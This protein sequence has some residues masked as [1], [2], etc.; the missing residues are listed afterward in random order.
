MLVLLKG[1]LIGYFE[2]ADV[3]SKLVLAAEAHTRDV[4][5][6]AQA[7]N[8]NHLAARG[9]QEG[10]PL[11]GTEDHHKQ[12]Q[13]RDDAVVT[14]QN[15][16]H[17]AVDAPQQDYRGE[18]EAEKG[19][20]HRGDK[21]PAERRQQGIICGVPSGGAENMEHYIPDQVGF[22]RTALARNLATNVTVTALSGENLT[23]EDHDSLH[24]EISTQGA[25]C[26]FFASQVDAYV[27][28]VQG[29]LV[30][31]HDPRNKNYNS[32][33]SNMSSI[34]KKPQKNETPTTSWKGLAIP[35]DAGVDVAN[36][37]VNQPINQSV[38]QSS[39]L[40][41]APGI[42]ISTT[43]RTVAPKWEELS[44]ADRHRFGNALRFI[45]QSAPSYG[46]QPRPYVAHKEKFVESLWVH[47]LLSQHS[48][49]NATF[50]GRSS[51]VFIKKEQQQDDCQNSTLLNSWSSFAKDYLPTIGVP[52]TYSTGNASQRNYIFGSAATNHSMIKC[53]REN[54]T[55][56]TEWVI[57]KRGQW[58]AG[59]MVPATHFELRSSLLVRWENSFCNR[60]VRI[61]HRKVWSEEAEVWENRRASIMQ[62]F[63]SP[64]LVWRD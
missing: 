9:A 31:Q 61:L 14:Y 29:R 5:V 52:E 59:I 55:E 4:A 3:V 43:G 57:K 39:T 49:C 8:K 26:Q 17:Q 6:G 16:G 38:N 51:D 42:L 36:V 53:D 40:P 41:L 10:G 22:A 7:E 30:L 60:S 62:R 44:A 54:K 21:I 25:G 33:A 34:T 27:T 47:W 19:G 37:T 15:G 12:V 35:L 56:N 64:V 45:S 23:T 18:R 13:K 50:S 28:W 1:L 24:D 58:N 63:V 32:D 48:T 11:R 46:L 20:H 2:F